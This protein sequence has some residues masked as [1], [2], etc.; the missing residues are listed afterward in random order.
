MADRIVRTA[1]NYDA[2]DTF[3]RIFHFGKALLKRGE[4][5]IPSCESAARASV[6]N[7]TAATNP[8]MGGESRSAKG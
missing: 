6:A 7:G 2:V 8:P 3:I 5:R 1:Q 4:K